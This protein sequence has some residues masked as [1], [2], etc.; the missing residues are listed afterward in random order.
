MNIARD[1]HSR[2]M[3][4]NRGVNTADASR[5]PVS[6]RS[7]RREKNEKKDSVFAGSLN[8]MKQDILAAKHVRK[9]K[10]ALK[11]IFDQ[12]KKDAVIDDNMATRSRNIDEFNEEGALAQKELDKV[13]G[14]RRQLRD[15]YG[16]AEDSEEE[17]DLQLLKKSMDPFTKLSEEEKERLSN[18]GPLTEYQKKALEYSVEYDE[19]EGTW[20]KRLNNARQGM[21]AERQTIQSIKLE[22][23]KQHPMTDAQKEAAKIMEAANE[24]AVG[25][26]LQQAKEHIDEEINKAKEKA[27]KQAEEQKEKEAEED[28]TDSE[29]NRA[30]EK[31]QEA[32]ALQDKFQT[33][34]KNIITKM[35]ITDEDLKGLLLDEQ[36]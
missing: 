21:T 3:Q 16:V 24:E 17:K 14:L 9:Q 29:S 8:I 2:Q 23:L 31:L 25:I 36:K 12:F 5:Q 11:R 18:M 34:L 30:L 26:I 27:E 28:G 13:E 10:E 33:D 6:A 7:K 32:D 20:K 15:A 22:L 4:D 1:D 19:M 35:N